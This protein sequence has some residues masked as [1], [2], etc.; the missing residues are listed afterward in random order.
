MHFLRMESLNPLKTSYSLWKSLTLNFEAGPDVDSSNNENWEGRSKEKTRVRR[1]KDMYSHIKPRA[2]R[3]P[4]DLPNQWGPRGRW[5]L[6]L[7]VTH[8]H[9]HEHMCTH[10]HTQT[11]THQNNHP[12][13]RHRHKVEPKLLTFR[14]SDLELGPENGGMRW[15]RLKNE[16]V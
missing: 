15:G 11:C 16:V 9:A 4:K 8:R 14:A 2:P 5:P 3:Q 6:S 12:F 7:K 1:A 13:H 10:A